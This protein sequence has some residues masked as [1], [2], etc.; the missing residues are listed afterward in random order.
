MLRQTGKDCMKQITIE[1]SETVFRLLEVLALAEEITVENVVSRLIDHALQRVYRPGAWERM[2]LVQ[3]FG[4]QFTKFLEPGDPYGR[5][6]C[7][8]IFERPKKVAAR[9]KKIVRGQ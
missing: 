8:H 3:A 9:F 2:W 7:E 5:P 1:I 6:A 4:D